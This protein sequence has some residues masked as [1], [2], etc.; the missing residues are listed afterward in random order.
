M[1]FVKALRDLTVKSFEFYGVSGN[2][3]LVQIYTKTGKYEGFEKSVDGWDLVYDNPSVTL[4]GREELYT[5]SKL[6][7]DAGSSDSSEGSLYST[8]GT[9]IEF[10]EGVGVSLFFADADPTNI[11][12]PRVF[13]GVIR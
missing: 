10:Y 2:T 12:S 5:P 11:W 8:D 1:F 13:K 6:I 4:K 9:T 7:Y 3:N